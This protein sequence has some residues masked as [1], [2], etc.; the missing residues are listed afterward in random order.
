[1]KKQSASRSAF[2]N[3]RNII[4]SA[5]F[6]LAAMVMGFAVSAQ[7]DTFLNIVYDGFCDGVSVTVTDN[8]VTFGTE[9]GCLSGPV[10]GTKGSVGSVTKQGHALSLA[11]DHVPDAIYVIRTDHTWSIYLSDGSELQSGT[12]SFA[13]A[14][15]LNWQPGLR[16]TGE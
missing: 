14:A 13:P 3:P 7:A 2:F 15:G 9:T 4:K 11:E 10:V 8:G 6:A 12:W 1:M 16:A 5:G